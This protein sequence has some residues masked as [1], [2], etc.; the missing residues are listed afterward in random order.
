MQKLELG[1]NHEIGSDTPHT[2]LLPAGM[3]DAM[4][5][6]DY[7]LWRI[8]LCLC[9]VCPFGTCGRY[10]WLH[11][12]YLTH[13]TPACLLVRCCFSLN[14]IRFPSYTSHLNWNSCCILK[15]NTSYC[16]GHFWAWQPVEILVFATPT[17]YMFTSSGFFFIKLK[18]G[19]F[20]TFL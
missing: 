18:W 9:K 10:L 5:L 11:D 16:W 7:Y 15:P 2:N 1:K 14:A 13:S 17:G 8:G 6:I 3:V 20:Y 12:R 4:D 19:I